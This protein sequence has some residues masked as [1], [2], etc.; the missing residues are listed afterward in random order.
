MDL[1]YLHDWAFWEH[2][3]KVAPAV[4]AL[5]ALIAA[6]IALV[7]LQTQKSLARKRSAIDFFLKTEMDKAMLEAYESYR[8]GLKAL[9]NADLSDLSGELGDH[10]RC[11]R[12]YLDVSELLAIGIN[13]KA[14][15]DD[16]CYG[17]WYSI[18]KRATADAKVV[19]Q[20]A[21]KE[22]GGDYTYE[23]LLIL[24]RRWDERDR[25]DRRQPQ[26]F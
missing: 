8:G 26:R 10:Y 17:F 20:H 16:V 25:T 4:T 18:L 2:V 5:V 11:V 6:T 9:R 14:F 22:Q 7:S 19:I 24:V 21:R 1:S 15:D 12:T 13:M 3:G 23:E